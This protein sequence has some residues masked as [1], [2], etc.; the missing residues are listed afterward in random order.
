MVSMMVVNDGFAFDEIN[1]QQMAKGLIFIAGHVEMKD[2]R[3]LHED[4]YLLHAVRTKVGTCMSFP[5]SGY[6]G[7]Q[8]NQSA[9]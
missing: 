4:G 3:F 9:E 7:F 2:I 5:K 8:C 6:I 1:R